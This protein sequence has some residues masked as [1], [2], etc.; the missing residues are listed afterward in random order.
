MKKWSWETDA[1]QPQVTC[2]EQQKRAKSTG[3]EASPASIPVMPHRSID[4]VGER[5]N[6]AK[7]PD[8]K[9]FNKK[10]DKTPSCQN[11]IKLYPGKMWFDAHWSQHISKQLYFSQF[12]VLGVFVWAPTQGGVHPHP[13]DVLA[14]GS[15]ALDLERGRCHRWSGGIEKRSDFAGSPP[16]AFS[17]SGRID[18]AID[19]E[20]ERCAFVG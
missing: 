9:N 17:R 5:S 8:K 20:D 15:I 7:G 14:K 3:D 12:R 16:A 18:D 10:Y 13:A 6:F 11:M 19:V 4:Q 1:T 2:D